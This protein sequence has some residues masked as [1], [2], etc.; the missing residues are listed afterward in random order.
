MS[1]ASQQ[2]YED[3]IRHVVRVGVIQLF[4]TPGVST[5]VQ[6]LPIYCLHW[7]I[8]CC[9]KAACQPNKLAFAEADWNTSTVRLVSSNV[10]QIII[11][12]SSR[13]NCVYALLGFVT[14]CGRGS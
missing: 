12:K 8:S 3:P 6:G 1:I 7:S 5:S 4:V 9:S 10:E 14:N 2:V 13:G 11:T